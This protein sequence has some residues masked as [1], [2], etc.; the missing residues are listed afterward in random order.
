[1]IVALILNKLLESAIAKNPGTVFPLV[2]FTAS[3][4]SSFLSQ[5]G[6]EIT[7]FSLNFQTIFFF[8]SLSAS[9]IFTCLHTLL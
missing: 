7:N 8:G 9:S 2:C 1:M 3:F 5:N 4:K 6:S